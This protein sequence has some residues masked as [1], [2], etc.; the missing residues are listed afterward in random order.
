MER[1]PDA[2][3]LPAKE[4]GFA[5]L[6][7]CAAFAA[8]YPALS[9]KFVWDDASWTSEISDLLHDFAGLRAM[10]TDPNAL[11]QYFPVTGTTFWLD[12]QWWGDWTT[13]YHVENLLLHVVSALLFWR[14]L[15]WLEVPGAWLAAGIFALHPTMV[16]SVAWI[17]ERKNVLSMVLYLAALLAY[18]KFTGF[19]K[20][21]EPPRRWGS[22]ALALLLFSLAL[23]SKISVFAFPA[24]LLLIAWWKTG[25]VRWKKDLLPALPF[26]AL[27]IGLGFFDSWLETHSLGAQG[28]DWNLTWPERFLVA[29]RALWFY[30]GQFVWPV[31]QCPIYPRWQL[32]AHSF[33]QWLWPAGVVLVLAGAWRLGRGPLAALL[34]FI[35]CLFPLLGFMNAYGTL[36]SFVAHR[37]AYV[38]SLGLIALAAAILARATARRPGV[39]I[40]VA[41]VLL[42]LLAALTWN[43]SLAYRSP[44]DFWKATF[45]VNPDCWVAW[46]NVGCERLSEGKVDEATTSFTR[47]IVL[48]PGYSEAHNN[49][50][51]AY[52][53]A[54]R[55]KEAME[56]FEKVIE[57]KPD[58]SRTYF[59]VGNCLVALGR[60]DEAVARYQKCLDLSPDIVEAHNNLA[61]V[62]LRQGKVPEALAQYREVT[63]LKPEDPASFRNLAEALRMTGAPHEAAEQY[64]ATVRV[65][66]NDTVALTRLSWLRAT[67]QDAALR[68]GGQALQ[69]AQHAEEISGG[70]NADALRS[71]AAAQ[72]ESGQFEK[73]AETARRALALVPTDAPLHDVLQAELRRYD[74]GLPVRE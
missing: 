65:D 72:A 37:W 50:G 12:H 33:V 47:A 58:R 68:N 6:L 1:R 61:L 70:K 56:Q 28:D 22:Y 40:G 62:L 57:L 27:A 60:L 43:A 53:R 34:Y 55:T 69:L 38:S 59:N 41:V 71:L 2:S 66:P 73:A 9:G 51:E 5:V 64:E 11:Q 19:W 54:G 49:L 35:G 20:E 16:E 63:R 29:G 30:A 74:F 46:Y 14:L 3:F 42:P 23:L 48:R 10:W 24:V 39:L 25:R 13:P 67:A 17:T 31:P 44:E 26:F 7:C 52:S 18:G 8:Y 21:T 45:A 15:R 4:I 36:Y 32:D